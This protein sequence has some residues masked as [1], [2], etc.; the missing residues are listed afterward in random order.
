MGD[1]SYNLGRASPLCANVNGKESFL[2]CTAT[3]QQ[4]LQFGELIQH[5]DSCLSESRSWLVFFARIAEVAKRLTLGDREHS[6]PCPLM[7]I[8]INLAG[9]RAMRCNLQIS[10]RD[11]L[12]YMY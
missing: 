9:H 11:G 1:V 6:I 5:F 12:V 7:R 10:C 4:I 3:C 8:I 2:I